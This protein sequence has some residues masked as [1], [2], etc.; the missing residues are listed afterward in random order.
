MTA[1]AAAEKGCGTG[2]ASGGRLAHYKSYR[3]VAGTSHKHWAL[4]GFWD[5]TLI[6]C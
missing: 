4:Q 6:W 5:E 3:C 2:H 1:E